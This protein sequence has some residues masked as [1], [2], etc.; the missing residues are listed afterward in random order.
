MAPTKRTLRLTSQKHFRKLIESSPAGQKCSR[1][2]IELRIARVTQLHDNVKSLEATGKRAAQQFTAL[3]E[4]TAEI[5]ERI[6]TLFASASHCIFAPPGMHQCFTIYFN[7]ALIAS[8]D[9]STSMAMWL[10]FLDLSD[11]SDDGRRHI[12]DYTRHL[13]SSFLR[14]SHGQVIDN[15][16]VQPLDFLLKAIQL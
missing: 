3:L 4:S 1:P 9:K 7:D 12:F 14:H 15:V 5:E 13:L 10:S 8:W 11:L 6:R 16:P 2:E